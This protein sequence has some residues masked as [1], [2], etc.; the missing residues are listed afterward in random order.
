MGRG[1]SEA[2]GSGQGGIVFVSLRFFLLLVSPANIIYWLCL[3]ALDSHAHPPAPTPSLYCYCY[4]N[5]Y[6]YFGL[7]CVPGSVPPP[8]CVRESKY[9]NLFKYVCFFR[10][11]ICASG[12]HFYGLPFAAATHFPSAS[13]FQPA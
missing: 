1:A 6:R 8:V 12:Q 10:V 2:G 9:W 7:A 4:L 13:P 5:R 11:F 3:W